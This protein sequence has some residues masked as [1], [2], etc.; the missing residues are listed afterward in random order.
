MSS[1]RTDAPSDIVQQLQALARSDTARPLSARF[2]D[3][4]EHVE[5]TLQAGVPR[6]TVRATLESN[7]LVLTPANFKALLH[8]CRAQAKAS[9]S[10]APRLASSPAKPTPVEPLAPNAPCDSLRA[11]ASA[12]PEL[13]ALARLAKSKRKQESA[14]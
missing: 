12:N 2:R 10:P 1:P 7:G 9:R 6:E 5:L 11:I 13:D 3:V 14:S 4:F 8:R